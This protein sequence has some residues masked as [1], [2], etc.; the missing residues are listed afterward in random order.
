MLLGTDALSWFDPRGLQVADIF[1]NVCNT[2]LGWKYEMAFEEG[3]KYKVGAQQ[4]CNCCQP[5]HYPS[6]T[7]WC[8]AVSTGSVVEGKGSVW[9]CLCC[10][11]RIHCFCLCKP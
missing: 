7:G 4:L 9:V 5:Q 1:C 2:N 8:W 6:M 10:V 11:V 3:Q